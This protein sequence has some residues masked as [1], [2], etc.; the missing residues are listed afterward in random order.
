MNKRQRM[1]AMRLRR[2]AVAYVE[3]QGPVGVELTDRE[4]M[5]RHVRLLETAIGFTHAW[6]APTPPQIVDD[7]S[8]DWREVISDD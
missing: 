8:I 6:D 1:W 2:A 7:A 4:R 3:A 5:R